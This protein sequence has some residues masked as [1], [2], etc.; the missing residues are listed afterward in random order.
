MD[1]DPVH[2]TRIE[3]GPLD[4]AAAM[5]AAS[6]PDA[7]GIAVFVGTVRAS[8]AV[9]EHAGDPVVRLD[10]DVHVDLAERRLAEIAGEASDKWELLRVV[11]I[12]RSGTCDL[13]EPTVVVACSA[14]HRAEALDACRWVIDEIK[15]TVPIFKREVY[16]DG[17][18]W[19]G[20]ESGS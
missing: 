14:P 19:V 5:T 16:A 18:S 9:E 15:A 6:T 20:T 1:T 2:L 7:G 17:S 4:V 11:A 8:A 12:H 10:Y 3:P 13:G